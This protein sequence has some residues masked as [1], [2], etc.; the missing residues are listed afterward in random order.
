[1]KEPIKIKVCGMRQPI[2]I[3]QVGKLKPDYMGL[4]FYPKSARYVSDRNVEPIINALPQRVIMVGVFVN[5]YIPEIIN[6]AN[7][8]DIQTI[9][10][11]GAENPEYCTILKELGYTVIKAFGV[12]ENFDFKEL[13]KYQSCCDYFLF[14]TKSDNHGGT[15]KKFDWEILNN[16]NNSKPIFLSGGI[17]PEDA[18]DIMNLKDLNIYS[19]DINSRFEIEPALKDIEKLET[20]INIIRSSNL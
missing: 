9:Q 17:G 12:D 5:E 6:K 4:I 1:M 2:N 13:D 14:D 10:L 11:H 16:Y 8:F 20:F 3:R 7:I 19:L 18:E 15:G